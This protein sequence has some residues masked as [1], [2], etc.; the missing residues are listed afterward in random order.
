M[1]CGIGGSFT[2]PHKKKSSGDRVVKEMISH[3][4]SFRK[5]LTSKWKCGDPSSEKV[6]K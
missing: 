2:K 5:A 4:C 1:D 6:N 3:S